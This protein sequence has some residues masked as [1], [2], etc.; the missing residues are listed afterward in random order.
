MM[1]GRVA[2]KGALLGKGL[3]LLLA[4][5]LPG[6]S[7]PGLESPAYISLPILPVEAVWRTRLLLSLDC[8]A[9]SLPLH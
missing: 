5:D 6:A 7:G 9:V 4:P 8:S 3:L 2:R 1:T